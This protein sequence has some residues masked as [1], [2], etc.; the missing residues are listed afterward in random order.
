MAISEKRNREAYWRDVLRRQRRSGLSI[1]A[2]CRKQD[3]SQAS[4]YYWKRKDTP[5]ENQPDDTPA[6]PPRR[7]VAVELTPPSQ[8][9]E[10]VLA[11]GKRVV[12]P[13]R[14]D[15]DHLRSVV[16]VLEDA[17]C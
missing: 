12:V 1:A 2:F 13:P 15:A 5:G 17:S 6:D 7:F 9:I 10:V 14:F 16:A 8:L 4:F 3:V 11:D